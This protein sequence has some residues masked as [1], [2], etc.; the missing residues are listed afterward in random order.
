MLGLAM[1]EA[2][3]SNVA[4]ERERLQFERERLL[5]EREE[6]NEERELRPEE[7]EARDILELDRHRM[8]ME[9]LLSRK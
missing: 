8:I 4:V 5:V 9:A 2:D 6:R 7:R 3:F 1:K